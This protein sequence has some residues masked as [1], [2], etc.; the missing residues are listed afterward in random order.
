[1]CNTSESETNEHLYALAV[2]V[3]C[4]SFYLHGRQSED[5]GEVKTT[6]KIAQAELAACL[7]AELIAEVQ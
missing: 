1:M 5:V 6:P 4:A 2:E 7:V 3:V